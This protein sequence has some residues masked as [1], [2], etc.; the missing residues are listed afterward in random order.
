LSYFQTGSRESIM[1]VTPASACAGI[2]SG[3]SPEN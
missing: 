3:G 1:I 2:N